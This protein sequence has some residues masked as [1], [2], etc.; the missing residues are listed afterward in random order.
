MHLFAYSVVTRIACWI[1]NSCRRQKQV[2][3]I[4]LDIMLH[5]A[6]ASEPHLSQI[7]FCLSLQSS[8]NGSRAASLQPRWWTLSQWQLKHT[9]GPI[10]AVFV[11]LLGRKRR[12]ELPRR[13]IHPNENLTE[14]TVSW[15]SAKNIKMG[16][17]KSRQVSRL[18]CLEKWP[19]L[20]LRL[21]TRW[22]TLKDHLF[23]I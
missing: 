23:L 17:I 4:K 5:P 2:F 22:E 8:R 20:M 16:L 9:P 10:T 18:T 13:M 14:K 1:P 6:S 12:A 11:W 19:R 7:D 15:V 3:G 21:S